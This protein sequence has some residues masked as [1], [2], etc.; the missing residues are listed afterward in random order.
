MVEKVFNYQCIGKN[1]NYRKITNE[2]FKF[3]KRRS[4][5]FL[6]GDFFDINNIKDFITNN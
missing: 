5:I 4:I 3:I 2:L 1:V 6:I